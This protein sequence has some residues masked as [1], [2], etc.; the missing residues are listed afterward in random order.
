[1]D[2]EP[3]PTPQPKA[4]RPLA[5]T[6]AII[7]GSEAQTDS[8][9]EVPQVPPP[10]QSQPEA[11]QALTGPPASKISLPIII[12]IAATI[13]VVAVVFFG[14]LRVKPGETVVAPTPTSAPL[15]TPTPFRKQSAIAS[16]SAFMEFQ[17]NVA[18]LSAAIAGYNP[19]DPMLT[20]PTLILPLGFS[21]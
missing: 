6:P 16:D 3:V 19:L 12:A 1:M 18:T 13:I 8:I 15:S 10:Q 14:I 5:E 17:T 4:D 9:S 7:T 2:T 20:P 11:D 21:R